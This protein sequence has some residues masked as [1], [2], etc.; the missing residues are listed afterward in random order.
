MLKS[1]TLQTMVLNTG[2]KM[3]LNPSQSDKIY[4]GLVGEVMTLCQCSKSKAIAIIIAN[5]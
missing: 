2:L 3:N 1:Q 4:D 5:N